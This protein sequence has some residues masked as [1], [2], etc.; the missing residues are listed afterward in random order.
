MKVQNSYR[1][2]GT[3]LKC[4]S[5]IG[6][7]L[8]I[9][10]L[11]VA[12]MLTSAN[13]QDH[14][15]D[16]AQASCKIP[17]H[18]LEQ[19]DNL[20]RDLERSRLSGDRKG[21]A[22]TLSSI[23]DLYR[24]IGEERKALEY[25]NQ[26][27]GLQRETADK[28][29]EAISL[30][31]LGSVYSYLGNRRKALDYFFQALQLAQALDDRAGEA[32]ILNNIG[33]VYHDLG[34]TQ[35][36]LENF[37]EA[38][39]RKRALRDRE[40]EAVVLNNFGAIYRSLGKE[41]SAL[42]YFNQALALEYESGE[43]RGQVSALNNIGGVYQ[44][45][46]DSQRALDYYNR[47]LLLERPMGER[48]GEAATLNNIGGVNEEEGKEK[49][50]LQYYEQALEIRR[51]TEDRVGEAV[52]LNNIG[53]VY[54]EL[55][56]PEKAMS[57]YKQALP[58][59]RAVEDKRG[60]AVTIFNIASLEQDLGKVPLHNYQ[61]A[62]TL[63]IALQDLPL[64]GAVFERSMSYWKQAGRPYL[65]I[66][67]GK[68]A[69]NAFQQ[70]RGN[71]LGLDKEL[72]RSFIGS[73]S[74][75]YRELDDLLISQG[76]LL[77]A[78]Q[79][80]DLLKEQ[81][82]KDFVR[83][84]PGAETNAVSLTSEEQKAADDLKERMD[85]ITKVG[86]QWSELQRN[87]LRTPEEEAQFQKLSAR[88]K[89]ANEDME[90]FFQKVYAS[91][92]NNDRANR[93]VEAAKDASKALQSLIGQLGP[94]TVALYTLVAEDRCWVIVITPTVIVARE[95]PIKSE[96]LRRK[97]FAFGEDLRNQ[98]SDPRANAQALY[99]ILMRPIEDDLKG[100]NAQTLVW[101]LDDVLRYVPMAALF[102][103]KQ[104]LVER[105][106]NVVVTPTSLGSLKDQPDKPRLTGLAMGISK[107]Y[108]AALSEL[109]S[110][111][112][113]LN[114][115]V[116]DPQHPGSK[117]V[118]AGVI[119]LDDDFTEKAMAEQLN[120]R[121]PLIHIASHFVF[122]PASDTNSYLLLSGKDVAG[123]GYHLTMEELRDDPRLRFN[124]TELLTLSACDTASS[125]SMADG[126]EVDGLETIAHRNGAKAVL[127]SLWNANDAST[128]QLMLDFYQ[129]WVGSARTTKIEALKQAQ[130]DL[131]LRKTAPAS[132]KSPAATITLS[133]PSSPVSSKL[134]SGNYSHPYYWAPFVL[135]GN[136]N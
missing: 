6:P 79:I 129:R 3:K 21:E 122:R 87:P 127:A 119:E 120:K 136:W 77:E 98:H 52:T 114:G 91:L 99:K 118:L 17:S 113:E 124:G 125:G 36:A 73:K 92:G 7:R 8:V 94:G 34:Q 116:R 57:Y 123:T 40:G 82:Y 63:A 121:Q 26:A 59:R 2:A 95:S 111:P 131:L 14:R 117:G 110:V 18:I 4:V 126:R 89:Q 9:S 107:Q 46:A 43:Q 56:Q 67:L 11:L 16:P 31:D 54:N 41:Q 103:G 65:A 50:A 78:R 71:M 53:N 58:I 93:T 74:W 108:E 134:S 20:Q 30:N 72:Q 85:Q 15:D 128:G 19:L 130:L 35:K 23:G 48:R 97:V 10:G 51:A 135:M 61:E 115:I 37:E 90:A 132:T 38:L 70:L 112:Q 81:E 33:Q 24:Q 62:L 47:A 25:Y 55:G 68:Q 80:L 84:D 27:L 106:S 96:E 66:F 28:R 13:A 5:T 76:R 69:I 49:E 39:S 1:E 101:S 104:Y 105:Y 102:D 109:P 133:N 12:A 88:L 64:E 32:T 44:D 75:A 22:K 45:L 83:G 29:A 86:E 60:E 100:A 42:D